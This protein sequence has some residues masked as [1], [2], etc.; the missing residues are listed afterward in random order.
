MDRINIDTI[1]PLPANEFGHKYIVAIID[2]FSRFIELWPVRDTTAL[3]AATAVTNF[4]GRYGIP[5]QILTDNGTQYANSIMK[6]VERL[7]K[8]EHKFTHPYSHQENG[9][10]ERANKE[11]LRHLNAIIFDTRIVEKWSDYLPLVQRI[12]NSQIHESIGVSPASIVFGNTLTLDRGI[13]YPYTDNETTKLSDWTSN[14]LSAQETIVSVAIA[15][16][17][18][19]DMFHISRNSGSSITEF[20]INSYVLVKYENEGHKPPTK[21]HTKLR[22][23][24]RVISHVGSIYTC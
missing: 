12:M 21:L 8:Y 20:P 7:F 9:I 3:S 10:V 14:M 17:N 4:A 22:G 24:L 18:S 11:I 16:Q 5:A 19:T 1:G 6:E 2:C 23:P 13:L 15:T